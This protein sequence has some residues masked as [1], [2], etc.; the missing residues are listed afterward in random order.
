MRR[1]GKVLKWSA[2]VF[3][4]LFLGAQGF[5]P[6]RTNPAVDERRTLRANTRMTPEVEAILRRSCNDCHS[7]ETAWP[8]YS[9]VAPASWFLKHHVDEGRRELSFSEWATYPKRKRERK[10]HEMCE[11]VESGE[12]PLKSYL[13]LHPGARLS[14]EDRRVLCEWTR[15]EEER[16]PEDA[17]TQ[18]GD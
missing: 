15:L 17:P 8:W 2:V 18:G 5:R 6:N 4:L 1:A 14:E 11:Q 7:S 3:S 16:Q 13:P 10:L 12:M 9:H